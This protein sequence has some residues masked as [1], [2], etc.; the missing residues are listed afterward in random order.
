MGGQTQF[1]AAIQR[2]HN[3]LEAWK[4]IGFAALALVLWYVSFWLVQMLVIAPF[5]L[6][7]HVPSWR[8]VSGITWA[9][10]A[11]LAVVGIRYTGR[12]LDAGEAMRSFFDGSRGIWTEDAANYIYSRSLAATW[13]VR[14]MLLAAPRASANAIAAVRAITFLRGER[15]AA[16]ERLLLELAKLNAWVPLAPYLGHSEVLAQLAKLGVVSARAGAEG[17]EVRITPTV[18]REYGVPRGRGGD[19]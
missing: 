14:N 13:I 1:V 5:F 12:L 4:A 18:F 8:L 17:N 16:A 10:M 7:G 2:Q 15:L 11:L 19:A 3:T 6:V 9:G